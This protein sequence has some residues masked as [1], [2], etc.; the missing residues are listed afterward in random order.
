MI[1]RRI[2]MKDGALALVS[3]GF[4]P[5]FL[6]RTVEGALASRQ[7]ILITIFQRGAVDG[8]NMIIPFGEQDYYSSRPTLAIAKPGVRREHGGRSER[9]LRHASADA[10]AQAVVGFGLHGDRA[11]VRLA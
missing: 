10:S 7:K 4:A 2:F 11:R 9:I 3:L 8:L 5:T 1:S 6:A